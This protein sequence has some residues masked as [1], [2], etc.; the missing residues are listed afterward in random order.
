MDK[1]TILKA[2]VIAF[3]LPQ[4]HPIPEN[5]KWWGEGFTEWTNVRKATPLFQEHYQPRIPADLGYYDLRDSEIRKAQANLAE[6]AGVSAF[7]YWHYWF[8]GGKQLLEKPLQEVLKIGEP[9][10][11]FCLAWANHSWEKKQWNSDAGLSK[12]LLM[13]QEYPDKNDVDLHFYTML[14][15]FKDDRYFKLHDK[16]VFVIYDAEGVLELD[17]F[18]NRW[19]ELA[20]KN[21][22]PGFYFIGHVFK[23]EQIN[24]SKFKNLDA[25]NLHLLHYAFRSKYK[26]L[27][28]WLFKKTLRIFPYSKSLYKWESDLFKNDKIYP[29]IYPNWDTTPRIGAMGAILQNSTPNLFKIHVNRIIKL[30][31]NKDQSDRVIFL[32]SWNEW[33]EGNYMEPDTKHGKGYI[34]ALKEALSN[35]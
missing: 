1:N 11:P 4:F 18:I 24:N 19:Q 20:K 26:R 16:L 10:F 32:K 15:V 3:Y 5:D 7:C 21:G 8:G 13:K 2:K 29:T 6:E 9:K 17:Y 22:L 31:S 12:E 27:I 30:I 28:Q 35:T 34:Y 23:I 14:P 25:I 33:A